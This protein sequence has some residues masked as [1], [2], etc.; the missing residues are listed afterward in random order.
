MKKAIKAFFA[1]LF[2]ILTVS[3]VLAAE[4]NNKTKT[5]TIDNYIAI[6]DFEVKNGD[7]GISGP[8]TDNVIHELSKSDKYEVI[9]RGNMNKILKEQKLQMS[10]CIS[11]GCIVQ[12]GQLLG[13]G[14][15]VTGSVGIV[16]KTY[17][18]TLQLINVQTGKIEISVADTCKCELDEL[19]DSTTRLAKKLLGEKVLQ[20]AV[21]APNPPT[22]VESKAEAIAKVAAN[23]RAFWDSVK[24][25]KNPDELKAYLEQFPTGIFAPLANARLKAI[26]RGGVQTQSGKAAASDVTGSKEIARDGRF[27]AYDNQTVLDTRTNLM[28]AAKDNGSDINWVNAKSYCENYRGGGYT[29]WRM[30]TRVELAGLYDKGKTYQT[31]G[32]SFFSRFDVHLTELIRL[33]CVVHWASETS[34]SDAAVLDFNLKNSMSWKSQTHASCLRALPVRSGK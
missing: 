8:L 15:I 4:K 28:W 31:E 18:L 32:S 26:E 6:F 27:I 20:P 13:V 25:S 16:G 1:L 30:P 3:D 7:K 9:D 24:D 2:L 12:A 5:E 14:K 10:G 34:L 29:D 23:D 19:L 11:G 17:Y 22:I 33:T 21:T